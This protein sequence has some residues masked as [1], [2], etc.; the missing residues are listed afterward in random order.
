VGLLVG[1]E[2]LFF[3]GVYTLGADWWGRFRNLFAREP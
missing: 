1:G 3:A 2:A